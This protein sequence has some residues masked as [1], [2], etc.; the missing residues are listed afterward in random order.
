MRCSDVIIGPA[1]GRRRRRCSISPARCSTSRPRWTT[2]SRGSAR[3]RCQAP[4]RRTPAGQ[5]RIAQ[6]ARS[7]GARGDRQFRRR[8]ARP[9]SPSSKPT[10]TT[11]SWPKC[12]ACCSEVSGALRML[13]LAAAGRL[14]HRRAPVHRQRTAAPP[15]RAQRPADGSPGRCA[16][17]PRVLPRSPARPAPEPRA[18]P[19]NRP[20]EPDVAWLLA[21]VGRRSAPPAPQAA[22]PA[23]AKPVVE[24]P[25]AEPVAEAVAAAAAS[26]P[27]PRRSPPPQPERS[28][29]RRSGAVRRGVR[30]S[31]PSARSVPAS[32]R[33]S[34]EIDD[35]IREVFLEEFEEEIENLA[36]LL[37]IWRDDPENAELLR[38]IRRVFHTL[39]GS[40]RL[41]GA[42]TLGEFSW[43]IESMLNRVLDG[44]RPASP[45]VFALVQ[46]ALDHLPLLRAALAGTGSAC[47]PRRHPGN[48]GIACRRR[49]SQLRRAGSASGR[50]RCR[51]GS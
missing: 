22:A 24:A 49:R 5:Q 34:D 25:V 40:G 48:C 47:R 50:S 3:T 7:P 23:A 35:E 19:R 29:G 41:V 2:R 36:Q 39:K 20:P 10:G 16:G 1:P 42:K 37:P 38:P 17:Q 8:R 33:S 15:P 44:S 32:R 45:Q 46:L 28:R 12:R 4:S 30:A 27:L 14:P 18:D 43:K 31:A 21:A 9:S 6:V 11:P 26:A 13:E 51:A